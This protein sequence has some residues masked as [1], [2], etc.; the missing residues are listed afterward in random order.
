MVGEFIF[1][2]KRVSQQ[3]IINRF[4]NLNAATNYLLTLNAF[5]H[6][7]LVC[8]LK[9]NFFKYYFDFWDDFTVL[10]ILVFPQCFHLLYNLCTCKH[11]LENNG[12]CM[13]NCA[14]QLAKLKVHAYR[15]Y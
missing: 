13:H 1:R 3:F 12:L 8:E 5:F 4:Q 9:N 11:M 14:I 15:L 10:I 2:V 7:A 6:V